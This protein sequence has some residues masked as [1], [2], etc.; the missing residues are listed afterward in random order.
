MDKIKVV[1]MVGIHEK[2]CKCKFCKFFFEELPKRREE[3]LNYEVGR[4]GKDNR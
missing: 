2:G 4:E 3:R 1:E